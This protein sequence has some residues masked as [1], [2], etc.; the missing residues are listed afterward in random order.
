[1]M[2]MQTKSRNMQI[3]EHLG[4]S[5]FA[6]IDRLVQ[7]D[8]LSVETGLPSPTTTI[9]STDGTGLGGCE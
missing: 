9:L 4:I 1:M 5:A 6:F 3:R 2:T 7:A 8:F